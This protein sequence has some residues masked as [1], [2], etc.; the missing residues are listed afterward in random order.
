MLEAKD[1]GLL[2]SY[3]PRWLDS[4]PSCSILQQGE[5][6]EDAGRSAGRTSTLEQSRIVGLCPLH[7]ALSSRN[8]K[9]AVFLLRNGADDSTAEQGAGMT[10]LH[11]A[12]A[13]DMELAAQILLER[14]ASPTVRDNEGRSLAL[15]REKGSDRVVALLR[16]L[17]EG[18][19]G[20]EEASEPEG[21]RRS[22]E[23]E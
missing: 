6:G 1:P 19:R 3:C 12:A 18:V 15:A 9:I 17:W 21:S 13:N 23:R 22:E 16:D 10:P 4:A 20:K 7:S 5:A 11:Y 8:S 2:D 14:G